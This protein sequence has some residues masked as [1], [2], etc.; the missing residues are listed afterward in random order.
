MIRAQSQ[1]AQTVASSGIAS[2]WLEG[3][4]TAQTAI[5]FANYRGTDM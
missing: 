2:T 4:R 3:G 5:E 1:I